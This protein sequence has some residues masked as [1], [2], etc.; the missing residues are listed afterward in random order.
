M[1]KSIL[2]FLIL[3]SGLVLSACSTQTE[4]EK[5][6]TNQLALEMLDKELSP[7]VPLCFEHLTNGTEVESDDLAELN[8]TK[9]AERSFEKKRSKYIKR[10]GYKGGWNSANRHIPNFVIFEAPREACHF[11]LNSFFH[12]K[13]TVKWAQELLIS[14]GF[15]QM[16]LEELGAIAFQKQS[17]R[18]TV[19][20]LYGG[21]SGTHLWIS[22][23]N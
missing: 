16:G 9:L 3:T 1:S 2:M 19:R 23:S 12:P 20:V 13:E 10:T 15:K 6:A 8:F 4:E 11:N 14:K 7:L 5:A 22:K 18:I 17:E 21:Q